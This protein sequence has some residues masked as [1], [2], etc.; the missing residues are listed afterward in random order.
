MLPSG[1]GDVIISI[2]ILFLISFSFISHNILLNQAKKI[3]QIP[4]KTNQSD[5][6]KV[7]VNLITYPSI[8]NPRV[9]Q[10]C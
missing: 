1:F 10:V 2:L 4:M 5:W 8:K 6:C 3:N 9:V 7:A